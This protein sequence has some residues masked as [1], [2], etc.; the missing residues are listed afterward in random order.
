M[1]IFGV[2]LMMCLC[3]GLRAE[4]TISEPELLA[5][6]YVFTEGP[7]WCKEGNYMLFSDIRGNA[8]QKWSE[9]KGAE[10]FLSPSQ[11]SNGIT[12]DGK[13]FYIC[14]YLERDVAKLTPDGK[15]TSIVSQYKGK[16]FNCPNDL[17]VT[18]K[19]NI[20][21]VDPGFGMTEDQIRELDF[22]GLFL[23]AKGSS[24]AVL[25]DESLPKPNGV[26]LSPNQELLYLCETS[27]NI[28]YSYELEDNG[29]L[30][31][32]KVFCKVTGKGSL[33]GLTV[34]EKTGHLFVALGSGGIV[35]VDPQGN[36]V[37]RIMFNNK[38]SVRNMC[39]GGDNGD[40]LYITAGTSLYRF[41]YDLSKI[42]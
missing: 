28:V 2:V 6:G 8:I 25:V 9:A 35:V 26:A 11:K 38:E 10:V 36:I 20:Y 39:F 7:V 3:C 17:I 32:K 24:E 34:Y 22:Q 27:E 30:S 31:N 29:M 18:N 21:M 5:T 42:K 14:R 1:R 41:N 37:D 4:Q 19:G 16:K 40:T 13:D 12:Y 23:I 33:D 15:A